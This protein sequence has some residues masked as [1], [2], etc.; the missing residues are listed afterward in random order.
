VEVAEGQVS[1]LSCLTEVA[2]DGERT[3]EANDAVPGRCIER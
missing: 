1:E 3:Y 2:A